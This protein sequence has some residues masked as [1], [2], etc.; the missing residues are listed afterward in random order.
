M[1]DIYNYEYVKEKINRELEEIDSKASPMVKA[2]SKHVAEKIIQFSE[3]PTFG[4]AVQRSDKTLI[5]CLKHLLKDVRGHIS[6]IDLYK[7]AVQF[8]FPSADIRFSMDILVS[9]DRSTEK[10]CISLDDLF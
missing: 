6:D 8:Y 2:V 10:I 9:E 7:R 3:N 1:A 5:D 4:L